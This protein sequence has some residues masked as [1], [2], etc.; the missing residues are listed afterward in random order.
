[1]ET[2]DN[3]KAVLV[4]ADDTLWENNLFFLQCVEWLCSVGRR[5]GYADRATSHILDQWE[6]R[7]IRLMGVG[8]HSFERSLLSTLRELA[9]TSRRPCS[10]HAGLQRKALRWMHF[11]RSHP[12]V[13]MEGV[14]EALPHLSKHFT[15]IVVTKGNP[16]DQMSK[17]HRSQLLPYL[18]AVE[19][20]W[21]KNAEDYRNVLAKHNLRAEDA[22]MVGN[23]PRS[24]INGAKRAGIRTVYVPHPQTWHFEME[25]ILPDLPAT[26]RIPHFGALRDVLKLP[27]P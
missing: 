18:A 9:L 8:Y 2:F 1:M 24:D 23:S 17:V 25:P 21:K 16:P 14:R 12:I 15:V 27:M 20:V 5:L 22:V 19:V 11:L 3:V 13:F 4:D 7:D 6:K 26:I 10:D